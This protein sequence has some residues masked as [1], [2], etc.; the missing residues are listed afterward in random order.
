MQDAT[1]TFGG[2][3]IVIRWVHREELGY[4][5]IAGW[6]EAMDVCEG[7]ASVDGEVIFVR[8]L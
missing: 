7:A 3:I 5:F 8:H 2:G 1:N 4:D 6:E